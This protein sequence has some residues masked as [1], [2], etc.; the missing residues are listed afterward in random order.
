MGDYGSAGKKVFSICT[1]LSGQAPLPLSTGGGGLSGLNE[2]PLNK[3]Q[4]KL[5]RHKKVTFSKHIQMCFLVSF[6]G[7]GM[8]DEFN[9]PS[10]VTCFVIKCW[11]VS[12]QS[13]L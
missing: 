3:I 9:L 12:A 5:R 10:T 7:P 11:V 4:M 13:D 2:A 8:M 6:E 1:N